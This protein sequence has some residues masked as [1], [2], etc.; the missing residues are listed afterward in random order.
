M[1]RYIKIEVGCCGDCPYYNWKKHKCSKGLR[2]KS[3]RRITFTVI[4]HLNGNG[5]RNRK[6]AYQ[7]KTRDIWKLMVDYG[8]GWECELTEFTRAEAKQRLKEYRENCP[9]YPA[10]IVMGRERIEDNEN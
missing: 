6:M 1:H 7:R 4:A 10:R 3:R 2:K 8:Q 5:R 9:Q